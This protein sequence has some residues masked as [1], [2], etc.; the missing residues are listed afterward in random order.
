M[1]NSKMAPS[2]PVFSDLHWRTNGANQNCCSDE[3]TKTLLRYGHISFPRSVRGTQRGSF[4]IEFD[5]ELDAPASTRPDKE[6]P[7]V[8]AGNRSRLTAVGKPEEVSPPSEQIRARFGN[9]SESAFTIAS[10]V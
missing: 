1:L 2:A 9:G 6:R 3:G 5:H 8:R 7:R 10:V 4:A